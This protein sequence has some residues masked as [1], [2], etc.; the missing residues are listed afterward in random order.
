[1]TN[2]HPTRI[3]AIGDLHLPGGSDK[4]M[5]VFGPH[6][7]GHF[8]KI[9]AD[10]TNRVN[11]N[12][13]VLIPGDISWA[14]QMQDAVPDLEAI[15][16]LPGKKIIIR[17]NHDYWWGSISRLRSNLPV[18]MYAI[19]ND[20]VV[21]D[22]MVFCGSRG[23]MLPN[24]ET[25]HENRKIYQ[26]ELL[27][28]ELSLQ[29]ARRLLPVGRLVV[30]IHYPPTDAIGSDSPMSILFEKYQVC[31]VVYG[32]LH[33]ASNANAFVGSI[34]GVRY[35]PVSCDGLDFQLYQLPNMA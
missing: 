14:M 21:L 32:H 35:H 6:W 30:M 28:M 2:N 22:D 23:W 26:R 29:H 24:D 8:D 10:W 33:G 19:Q 34:H 7:E 31:D 20:A 25:D 12:D 17:G 16:G 13:I 18:G 3:Y 11:D 5:H 27:R 1:M 4:P 9:A 15:G